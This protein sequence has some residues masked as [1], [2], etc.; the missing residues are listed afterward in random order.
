MT[1]RLLFCPVMISKSAY[2]L[3]GNKPNDETARKETKSFVLPKYVLQ[4][5][6]EVAG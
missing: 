6:R 4:S 3:E 1:I 5:V 2:L